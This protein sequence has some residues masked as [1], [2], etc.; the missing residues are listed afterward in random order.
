MAARVLA[1]NDDGVWSLGLKLLV[2]ALK[3][4]GLDVVVYAPLGDWSGSGKCTG[5]TDPKAIF[6]I[7]LAGVS[8]YAVNAPPAM[9]VEIGLLAE[10][11]Y[12]AVVS[13]INQ[14]PNVGVYDFFTSGTIGAALEAALRGVPAVAVS[15][16]CGDKQGDYE[17][18]CMGPAA[19]V[20]AKITSFIAERRPQ[21]FDVVIVNAPRPPWKGV[22]EATM[23]V[24]APRPRLELRGFRAVI[25]RLDRRRFYTEAPQGS[26]A[27]AVLEGYLVLVTV[28]VGK[29]GVY[30]G[31]RGREA[32]DLRSLAERA[33]VDIG[34]VER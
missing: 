27:R 28:R 16:Y 29:D 6:R 15:S 13:G 23:Y 17:D 7:S 30:W 18:K 33:A 10:Q 5:K 25:G 2:K 32:E 21:T 14:G 31:I 11:G 1:T 26:D 3:S 34:A 9:C 12:D 20:A 8:G 19:V 24:G 22:I 4:E